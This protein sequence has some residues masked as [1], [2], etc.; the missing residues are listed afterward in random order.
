MVRVNL[1]TGC[2]FRPCMYLVNSSLIYVGFDSVHFQYC[3]LLYI[4]ESSGGKEK[5][6]KQKGVYLFPGAEEFS[7][8][9]LLGDDFT[10]SELVS[11]YNKYL[12][13]LHRRNSSFWH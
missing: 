3:L 6:T 9:S 12:I 11:V 5:K 4:W 2:A 10:C 13:G 8:N 7:F 1:L